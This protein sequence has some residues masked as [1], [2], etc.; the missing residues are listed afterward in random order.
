[1]RLFVTNIGKYFSFKY[2]PNNI[3]FKNV[4]PIESIQDVLAVHVSMG[5]E[6]YI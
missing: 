4:L 1:M 5:L 2:F 3:L 6:T